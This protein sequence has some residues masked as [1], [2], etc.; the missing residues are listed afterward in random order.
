M[1]SINAVPQFDS[2]IHMA[3]N[4][5]DSRLHTMEE[6]AQSPGDSFHSKEFE[7]RGGFH[8]KSNKDSLGQFD[9]ISR[10]NLIRIF[11]GFLLASSPM[12]SWILFL[13]CGIIE[14]SVIA[15]S[16]ELSWFYFRFYVWSGSRFFFL[17][18]VLFALF[19]FLIKRCFNISSDAWGFLF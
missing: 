1:G 11:R 19:C 18:F 3:C 15:P 6:K 9:L 17:F 4:S 16:L 7:S 10:P 2:S 13:L 12:L 5:E 8:S 14:G